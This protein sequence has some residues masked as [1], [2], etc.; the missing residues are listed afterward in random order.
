MLRPNLRQPVTVIVTPE[1]GHVHDA[2]VAGPHLEGGAAIRTQNQ[3]EK[4][5]EG[6]LAASAGAGYGDTFATPD[7]EARHLQPKAVIAPALAR[8]SRHRQDHLDIPHGKASSGT[9]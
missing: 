9:G 7:P 4:I 3:A 5:E 1:P 2:A 8:R 6:A